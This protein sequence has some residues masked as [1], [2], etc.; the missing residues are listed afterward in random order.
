MRRPVRILIVDD[1]AAVRRGIRSLLREHSFRVC[2]E[3]AN[4]WEAI[5][6]TT[7]L[8]PDIILM[9]IGMPGM[10]GVRAAY[11]IRRVAPATKIVFLTVHNLPAVALS[12]RRWANG[13]VSKAVAGT[14]LIPLLRLLTEKKP[15]LRYK[16]DFHDNP[17]FRLI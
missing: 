1:A 12:T 5:E 7:A 16:N 11:E 9:D 15:Q 17:V 2:G 6:K 4:G 13:Y 8:R 3:A 10:S 14:Q